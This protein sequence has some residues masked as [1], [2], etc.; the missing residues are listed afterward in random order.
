MSLVTDRCICLRKI[1]YSE[2]S[3]VLL[4]FS[5]THGILRVIAKG[6]H[7]TTRQGAS[8]FGGGIDLLD[9]ADAVFS[10]RP[11]RDLSILAEWTLLEGH[12]HLRS[13]LRGLYLGFYAAEIVATLVHEHDPQPRI[14]AMLERIFTR[15]ATPQVEQAFV[16]F[17]IAVLRETGYLPQV[18]ACIRCGQAVADDADHELVPETAS[19]ATTPGRGNPPMPATFAFVPSRGGVACRDCEHTFKD[20]IPISRATLSGIRELIHLTAKPKTG[21]DLLPQLS[22]G[23]ADAINRL[24]NAQLQHAAGKTLVVSRYVIG[25]PT[26]GLRLSP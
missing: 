23:H 11:E 13:D 14:F 2:S 7:R 26:P 4:I 25:E 18:D 20:S 8:K 22:R 5:R 3:Q 1:D 19:A 12:T 21:I 6:A 24:L 16:A 10:D 9:V 17:Q 15:L